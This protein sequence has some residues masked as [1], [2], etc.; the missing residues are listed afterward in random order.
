MTAAAAVCGRLHDHMA[1][2]RSRR[3]RLITE[4]I[5]TAASADFSMLDK[6]FENGSSTSMATPVMNPD[7][8]VVAPLDQFNDDRPN[9]PPTG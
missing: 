8:Q 6:T 9:E 1:E 4:L 2:M 5:T 3:N 7:Q